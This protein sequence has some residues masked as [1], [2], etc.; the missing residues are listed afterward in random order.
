MNVLW[1]SHLLPFPPKGGVAQRS[2]HLIKQTAQYN[3]V[4]LIAFNQ[5]AILSK[6]T[7]IEIAK[8][9]FLKYC[10]NVTVLEIPSELSPIGNYL[11]ALKS[12][13][14]IDPYN[15][16]WLKSKKMHEIVNRFMDQNQYDLVWFDTI[17]L[18][19]YLQ[20]AKKSK[21]I[22]NH[23]NIESSMMIRRAFK[24]G[25]PFLK[26]YFFQEGFKLRLAEHKYCSRFHLNVTCSELDSQRLIKKYRGLKTKVV[27][28][29]VDIEYFKCTGIPRENKTLV[30]AGDLAWY[31]NREA[32]LHFVKDIWPLL[33][34][35]EP[36]VRMTV[37]GKNPPNILKLLAANDNRFVVTGF[38]D[39]VRPFIEKAAVYV[40]PIMNGGGTKLKILD[41]LA[42]E[43]AIVAHP[44]ACEGIDVVD[45]RDVLYAMNPEMYVSKI[46]Y[47]FENKT[48]CD[49]LG[50]HGRLLIENLYSFDKI[51]FNMDHELKTICLSKI[52]NG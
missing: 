39:D 45:G 42:M 46:K 44:I 4:D 51:G 19:P 29:G 37:I 28:N 31:P 5:K 26:A 6:S 22:L 36:D 49:K 13:F 24:E 25:N 12:L 10:N 18:V 16:N 14:T 20:Y 17:S 52:R 8:K 38:V 43:K 32:M 21:V 41:A 34:A 3:R 50:K 35:K 48:E 11:L 7:D 40:C 15:L 23:H 47:L 30:F 2:Y 33:I 1:L 9:E 27:P